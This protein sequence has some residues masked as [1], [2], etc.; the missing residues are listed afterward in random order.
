MVEFTSRFRARRG[1]TFFVQKFPGRRDS[2][3]PGRSSG[4]DEDP[5]I[6]RAAEEDGGDT[7]A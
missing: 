2:P 7:P 6:A 3:P 4:H 1:Y 5:M